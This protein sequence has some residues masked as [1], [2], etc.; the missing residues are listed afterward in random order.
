MSMFRG[1]FPINN[2]ERGQSTMGI[3][4]MSLETEREGERVGGWKKI[5]K[6]APRQIVYPD[7]LAVW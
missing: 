1:R 3:F 5:L 4:N 7:N 2:I 6:P